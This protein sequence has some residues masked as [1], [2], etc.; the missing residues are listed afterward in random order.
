MP[1]SSL[2]SPPPPIIQG[3]MPPL[4]LGIPQQP[5]QGV[6]PIPQAS[7]IPIAP[8]IAPPI[9]LPIA[10]PIAPPIPQPIAPPIAPP[11]VRP[12]PPLSSYPPAIPASS[13]ASPA[14][15]PPPIPIP[16]GFFV[17]NPILPGYYPPTPPLSPQLPSM[18]PLTPYP[19]APLNI[20][21]FDNPVEPLPEELEELKEEEEK[22]PQGDIAP[23]ASLPSS[24]LAASHPS[25]SLVK[26]SKK[27][28]TVNDIRDEIKAKMNTLMK[29]I[30][31]DPDYERK[32][33][34]KKE[35]KT[36][37]KEQEK[38]YLQDSSQGLSHQ[39]AKEYFN[40]F[41][42]DLEKD[43]EKLKRYNAMKAS[44]LDDNSVK[45]I[46]AK[47]NIQNLADAR[48]FEIEKK[49]A[50]KRGKEYFEKKLGSVKE[51]LGEKES[52]YL[53][54]D[55]NNP[56]KKK[57]KPGID[58]GKYEAVDGTIE[59]EKEK[60][61]LSDLFYN[62][63]IK[64]KNDPN[65]KSYYLSDIW[66][67]NDD[68]NNW[69]KETD[70][71]ID[72]I[73]KN[74]RYMIDTLISNLFR[75]KENAPIPIIFDIQDAK[76]T[77]FAIAA[78][79]IDYIMNKYVKDIPDKK[80]RDNIVDNIISYIIKKLDKDY[81]IYNEDDNNRVMYSEIINNLIEQRKSRIGVVGG[82]EYEQ[83]IATIPRII[84][85]KNRLD[86]ID[87]KH[88]TLK[89]K[90]EVAELWNR[91]Y[92]GNKGFTKIWTY[93]G[94]DQNSFYGKDRGSVIWD[95]IFKSN[96]AFSKE[97][98]LFVINNLKEALERREKMKEPGE[99]VKSMNDIKE[100][101]IKE[102]KDFFLSKDETLTQEEALQ[103]FTDIINSI[104]K[105]AQPSV[106]STKS[107]INTLSSTKKGSG[108][109]KR[110]ILKYLKGKSSISKPTIKGLD[111]EIFEI[112]NS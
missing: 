75:I 87:T 68:L 53:I 99:N 54:D 49:G 91:L 94:L 76:G 93:M 11:I 73:D 2:A 22:Y 26:P 78:Q 5:P 67:D 98:N 85:I 66:K 38:L 106:S 57:L 45:G 70:G 112:L 102:N 110:R 19:I 25:V 74:D 97:H 65:Y 50:S 111:T 77:K 103:L 29:E 37:L 47:Q 64:V 17:G 39:Q 31:A 83:D 44:L 89:D 96:P 16:P 59:Q 9:A 100:D 35:Y 20:D 56:G 14:F 55:P 95:K 33:R 15:I 61:E 46:A 81:Y 63:K 109:S 4:Y 6:A 21:P 36:F 72:F 101:F 86:Q 90:L 12:A 80:V 82:E 79:N 60:V 3:L 92:N 58:L 71:K 41:V 43:N 32:K 18:A 108:I 30:K 8:L 62:E 27:L 104:R 24:S 40:N 48:N 34:E 23:I 10:L 84:E 51:A 88:I 105:S 1:V 13:L 7:I 52:K 28:V 107:K 69:M 42:N